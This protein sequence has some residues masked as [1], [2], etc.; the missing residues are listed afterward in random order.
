M[1]LRV[2]LAGR[3]CVE[4]GGEPVV[5]ESDFRRRQD[6][7]AFA[8]LALER[9][10]PATREELA[11]ALW[12]GELPPAWSTGLSAIVSRLRS[13]LGQAS[14]AGAGV[15]ISRGFGQYRLFLPSDVWVDVEA[16]AAALDEAELALKQADARRALPPAIVASS[17][18]S[19]PFLSG[20]DVGWASL[21]REK[22]RRMQV[23]ALECQAKAWLATGEPQWAVEAAADALAADPYRESTCRLL[24]QAHARAGNPAEAVR[25]YHRLRAL[26]A[27]ELGTDPSRE[28]EAVLLEI[29]G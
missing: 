7:V 28:T 14:L 19:R 12:P 13:L 1:T 24:M 11:E 20:D 25:A 29:L 23:R 18:T 6:R 9:A 27:D 22:L 4:A 15:S 17:I 10:R 3:V 8:Y 5:R 16:A 2:Y 21:E 26:L